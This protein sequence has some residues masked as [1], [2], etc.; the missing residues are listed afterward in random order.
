M[1]F[2]SFIK[3]AVSTVTGGDLLSAGVGLFGGALTNQA[4]AKM[5]D[6]QMDFQ[7]RMSNTAHQRQVKDL[8]AAGLNPILS[9]KL[10]G[11]SSPAGATATMI[12]SAKEGLNAF[13]QNR[14][15][16]EQVDNVN[17]DSAL[18]SSQEKKAYNE[19]QVAIET[20]KLVR[21][22]IKQVRNSARSVDLD[23][24][25]KQIDV[26][27]FSEAELLKWSKTL[28]ISPGGVKQ[29]FQLLKGGKK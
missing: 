19:S 15:L 11:A 16:K 3:K 2:G 8:R 20:A 22:Q 10:G 1:G 17:I 4:N 13:Q 21:E 29:L 25:L 5:A 26:D 18:K 12:N 7:E 27:L 24:T 9:A 28:G 14:L 23:N 6:N